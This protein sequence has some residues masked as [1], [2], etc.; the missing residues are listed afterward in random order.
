MLCEIN[1]LAFELYAFHLQAK[2][3]LGGCVHA[4][5][6]FAAGAQH[7]I[8]GQRVWRVG[9]QESRDGAMI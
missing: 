4:E 3:L 7:T 9:A 6:D 2:T 1:A 8:P 5:F